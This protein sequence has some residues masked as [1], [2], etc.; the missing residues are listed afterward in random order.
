MLELIFYPSLNQRGNKMAIER[1]SDLKKEVDVIQA[2]VMCDGKGIN[3]HSKLTSSISLYC[4]ELDKWFKIESIEPDRM[5][6]CGCWS[7]IEF[8]LVEDK[9]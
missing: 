3:S 9:E 2:D 7:G 5:A 6:G 4:E 1:L 8:N